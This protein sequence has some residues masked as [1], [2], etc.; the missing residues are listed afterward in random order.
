M[1]DPMKSLFDNNGNP[2]P[3]LTTALDNVLRVQ[4]PLVLALVK[5][6]R[7]K[8]PHETPAQLQKRLEKQY[9]R[10]VTAIGG[11]TGASSFVPGVGTVTSVGLSVVA[12]GGYLERTAIFAQAIAELHGVHVINPE[13]ARSMVMA[14]MLGEEGSQ[15]ITNILAK[16]GRAGMLSNQWG[17]LMGSNSKMFSVERALRNM[18]IKRFMGRQ[19][20]MMMG[21]AIPFGVGA[22]VGGGANL[23]LGREV[24]RSTREAFGEAPTYFPPEL[25]L[26][27]RAPRFNDATVENAPA[28]RKR[29]AKIAGALTGG[30]VGV[31]KATIK[32][33][34]HKA[35]HE[36]TG[37]HDAHS[38]GLQNPGAA[39]RRMMGR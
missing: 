25:T 21:R 24:I 34:K 22:V 6:L 30:A 20:G 18:F 15:L 36:E 26:P 23:A 16:N 17:M 2:K 9:L 13:A 35:A 39:H 14:L 19:A 3:A 8:Y 7:E 37:N 5:A 1:L 12:I 11:V 38:H 31:A 28:P 32:R 29:S 10:D 27:A 4:R 33:R